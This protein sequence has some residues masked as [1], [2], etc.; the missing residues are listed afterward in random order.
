[1]VGERSRDESV[2]QVGSM[3][4]KVS[5]ALK[6][7]IRTKKCQLEELCHMAQKKQLFFNI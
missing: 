3:R 5:N 4:L 6:D 7:H 1:M 2:S